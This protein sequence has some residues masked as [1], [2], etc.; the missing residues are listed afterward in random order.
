MDVFAEAMAKAN[1]LVLYRSSL[2]YWNPPH[3]REG[4]DDATRQTVL[5]RIMAALSYSGLVIE[6]EGGFP[7]PG[8]QLRQRIQVEH[9]VAEATRKQ[10]PGPTLFASRI[11]GRVGSP[12]KDLTYLT[13][14]GARQWTASDRTGRPIDEVFDGLRSEFPKLAIERLVMPHPGE[15]TNVYWLTI[16]PQPPGLRGRETVQ[17]D[18]G[19]DGRRIL[20]NEGFNGS[21]GA[22]S[23]S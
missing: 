8:D 5:D 1:Y 10:Q 11:W 14:S 22:T 3:T 21:V 13:M 20:G 15:D 4:M 17:L 19:E 6:L 2:A 7:Q 18:T 16:G 9:A 23:R 12:T